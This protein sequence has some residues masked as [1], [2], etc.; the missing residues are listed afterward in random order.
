MKPKYIQSVSASRAIRLPEVCRITGASR[1]TVWRWSKTD[2]YFPR[3][4][5][6]GPALTAWDE[7]EIFAWIEGKKSARTA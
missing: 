7:A 2:P 4:F 3:P 5:K 6:V 1:A